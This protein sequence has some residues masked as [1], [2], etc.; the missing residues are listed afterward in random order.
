MYERMLDKENRPTEAQVAEHMGAEAVERLQQ[1]ESY[2]RSDYNLAREM[3]FPYG[4]SYGWGYKYSH[5]SAHLCD[6]FFE[7]GA[8]TVMLQVGK[9]KAVEEIMDELSPKAQELWAE[10]HPCGT[11]G[12]GWIHYQVFDDAEVSDVCKFVYARKK[13]STRRRA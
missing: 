8:F 2:L 11:G 4:N 1:F 9:A 3:R 12:G 5:K 10:R 6:V 7:D 13:P